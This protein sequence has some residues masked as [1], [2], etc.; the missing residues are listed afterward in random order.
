MRYFRAGARDAFSKEMAML[1][2]VEDN[3]HFERIVAGAAQSLNRNGS[4]ILEDVA[5]SQSEAARRKS[6]KS[7]MFSN[8]LRQLPETEVRSNKQ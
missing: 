3:A 4:A 7:R 1:H 6:L 2:E 8:F 5:T